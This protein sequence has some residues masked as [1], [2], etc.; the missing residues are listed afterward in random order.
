MN[1]LLWLGIAGLLTIAPT[2]AAS[3]ETAAERVSLGTAQ[4]FHARMDTISERSGLDCFMDGFPQWR[5]GN[6]LRPAVGPLGE[7]VFLGGERDEHGHLSGIVVEVLRIELL[8]KG[9]AKAGTRLFEFEGF[10]VAVKEVGKYE[11]GAIGG[12]KFGQR[13]ST[14][15]LLALLRETSEERA[16]V[17]EAA[18]SGLMRHVRGERKAIRAFFLLIDGKDPSRSFLSRFS[19]VRPEVRPGSEFGKNQ[20]DVRINVGTMDINWHSTGRVDVRYSYDLVPESLWWSGYCRVEKRGGQW[21]DTDI[22]L[23]KGWRHLVHH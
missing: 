5:N 19:S 21:T 11:E 7:W 15:A 9:K 14:E 12:R 22:T 17:L 13:P 20:D 10:D 4:R 1:R 2:F 6:G 3:E 8:P 16:D 23:S 18:C